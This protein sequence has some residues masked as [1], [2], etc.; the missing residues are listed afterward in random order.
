MENKIIYIIVGIVVALGI[1][2]ASIYTYSLSIAP[3]YSCAVEGEYSCTQ[4]LK[5]ERIVCKDGYWQFVERCK[6]GTTYTWCVDGQCTDTPITEP[7]PDITNPCDVYPPL[8]TDFC[9]DSNTLCMQHCEPTAV[10]GITACISDGCIYCPY[11]CEDRTDSYGNKID[12]VCKSAPEP[13]C[14]DGAVKEGHCEDNVKVITVC[15]NG[16]WVIERTDCSK[17]G[18]NYVCKQVTTI[19]GGTNAVCE[20]QEPAKVPGKIEEVLFVCDKT[21]VKEGEQI[22]CGG[23]YKNVGDTEVKGTIEVCI[24]PKAEFLS[25]LMSSVSP[26]N[27]YGQCC[28]GNDFCYANDI[29]LEPGETVNVNFFP[30]APT[31]SSVDNCGNKV[32]WVGYGSKYQIAVTSVTGCFYDVYGNPV[33]GNTDIDPYHW[34]THKYDVTITEPQCPS[35]P[36]PGSWSDCINGKKTRTNYVCGPDTGYECKPYTETTTCTVCGNGI[37]EPGET[38]ASC[39]Q[40]CYN[41]EKPQNGVCTPNVCPPPLYKCDGDVCVLDQQNVF[42]GIIIVFLALIA[43]SQIKK[44]R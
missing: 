3:G 43:Y 35:C 1:S 23:K 7:K 11:G 33:G 4:G 15:R 13:V 25:I 41:P 22:I 38:V 5:N 34:A 6:V 20:Y 27:V 8:C 9:Y 26:S 14:N 36:P 24:R 42:M 40:D 12:S 17:Y 37:C 39:Y 29:T 16:E 21:T 10:E 2:L 18:E 28:P 19:T 44:R 31:P 32:F 30:K